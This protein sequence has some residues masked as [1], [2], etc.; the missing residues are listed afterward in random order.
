MKSRTLPIAICAACLAAN[1]ALGEDAAVTNKP[2]KWDVSVAAGLT[3]TSGNSKTL[4]ATANGLAVRKW[5]EGKNE[6]DLGADGAYG[7]NDEV[8]NANQA[9]GFI[10][11]NRLFTERFYGY[12]RVDGLYNPISGIKYRITVSPGVGY[13]FIKGTNT[14][15]RGE[16]G[17]GYLWQ[18][19]TD[20]T[21]NH[22]ATLRFAERFEQ[23]ISA[24][25]KFYEG[26][27]F[28]PQVD[29]WSNYIING[30]VGVET[31]MTKKTSLLAYLQDTYHSQPVDGLLKNDLKVVA[32]VKYTF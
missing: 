3:Y 16:I 1:L 20:N 30:T 9:H 26:V 29:D 22:Y 31:L 7:K 8:V 21:W 14:M 2:P 27:E 32:A 15:L 13:Y 12:L 24:V 25:A 6:I 4:L 18:D 23:K 17:P 11:Y 19:N 10:Q 5:D 28:L